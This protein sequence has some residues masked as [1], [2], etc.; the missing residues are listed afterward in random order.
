VQSAVPRDSHR[1]LSKCGI[2][3]AHLTW[4]ASWKRATAGGVGKGPRRWGC[5]W[6]APGAGDVDSLQARPIRR[7][8]RGIP[9][10]AHPLPSTYTVEPTTETSGG[11]QPSS[12]DS[13]LVKGVDWM[14]PSGRRKREASQVCQMVAGVR[15]LK[16]TCPTRD[17]VGTPQAHLLSQAC[18]RRCSKASRPVLHA[19]R[20]RIRIPGPEADRA[21]WFTIGQ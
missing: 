2:A 6:G 21:F 13:R 4:S 15:L 8:G 17:E 16:G 1:S 11:C 19:A 14:F 3:T 18:G 20:P 10:W 12:G 7:V 9:T 5:C